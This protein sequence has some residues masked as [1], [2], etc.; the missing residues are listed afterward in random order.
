MMVRW[1]EEFRQSYP[2]VQFDISAGGA[3][4]GLADA[5]GGVVDIGMVSRDITPEEEKRGAFWVPVTTDAVFATV[6]RPTRCCRTCW[7]KVSRATSWLT[8]IS[9]E[10]S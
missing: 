2:D 6:A 3:G 4:K 1:S 8:S 7:S 9:P 5:L 10:R